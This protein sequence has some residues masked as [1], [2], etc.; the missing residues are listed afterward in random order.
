MAEPAYYYLAEVEEMFRI[1]RDTLIRWAR[2]GIFELQ[3]ENRD[4]RERA[5]RVSTT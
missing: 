2:A 1:G 4:R 3:G 5:R